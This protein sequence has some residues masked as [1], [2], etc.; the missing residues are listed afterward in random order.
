MSDFAGIVQKQVAGLLQIL[1]RKQ[2][3]SC[4]EITRAAKERAN[5]LIKAARRQSRERMHQAIVEERKR[6]DAAVSQATGRLR[7]DK[8]HRLQQ[9]YKHLLQDGWAVLEGEMEAR[10]QDPQLRRAW[11]ASLLEDAMRM[12]GSVQ[13]LIEHPPGFGREDH[14][15]MTDLV[16][17]AGGTRPDFDTDEHIRSG[18]RI[19]TTHACLDGTLDGLLSDRKQIEA[20]LLAEWEKGSQGDSRQAASPA[21]TGHEDG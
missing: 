3:E 13:F 6:I 5:N 21:A 15:W 14:A 4:N 1:Q 12:L 18:L 7:T 19:R 8:R 17:A 2:T 20:L 9:V 16:T 10:W 11:C